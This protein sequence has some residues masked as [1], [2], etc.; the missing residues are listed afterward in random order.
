VK[1]IAP[2]KYLPGYCR[3]DHYLGGTVTIG[4]MKLLL[5]HL[6]SPVRLD[7]VCA[8][9]DEI[10]SNRKQVFAN[11][12]LDLISTWGDVSSTAASTGSRRR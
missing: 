5:S 12:E 9:D 1:D 3:L 11:R 2:G 10:V 7:K 6:G 4:D 8:R